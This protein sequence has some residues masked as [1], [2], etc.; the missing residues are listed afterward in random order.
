[1]HIRIYIYIE[2]ERDNTRHSLFVEL[3]PPPRPWDIQIVLRVRVFIQS[4]IPASQRCLGSR[5]S[6]EPRPCHCER[7]VIGKANQRSGHF[8]P[9][10]TGFCLYVQGRFLI[11][12]E[13]SDSR[14]CLV[15]AR[16]VY[17][18]FVRGHV[19]SHDC[20]T[21]VRAAFCDTSMGMIK[22]L[23]RCKT[24]FWNAITMAH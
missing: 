8:P 17:C 15:V 13:R 20:K 12:W 19:V 11:P 16:F 21:L 9:V 5:D 14:L 1:M 23:W 22:V 3:F 18:L 7:R 2:R 24:H 10:C 4:M 6:W